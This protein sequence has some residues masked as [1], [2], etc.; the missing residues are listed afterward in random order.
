MPSTSTSPAS[1]RATAADCDPGQGSDIVVCGHRRP[2][3]DPLDAK[4]RLY[5]PKPV[6]AEIGLGGGA[7]VN[8]HGEDAQVGNAIAHR[9]MVTLKVPF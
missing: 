1:R 7:T 4:A 9:V 5:V 2:S 8:V 3:A 6:R